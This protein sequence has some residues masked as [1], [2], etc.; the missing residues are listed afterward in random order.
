MSLQAEAVAT[1]T[2]EIATHTSVLDNLYNL[3]FASVVTVFLATLLVSAVLAIIIGI[4]SDSHSMEDL[5]TNFIILFVGMLF[6]LWL[7]VFFI[8]ILIE[9]PL[10]VAAF[11][12][13]AAGALIGSTA[14]LKKK[15]RI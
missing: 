7:I 9:A 14:I 2:A 8:K 10:M 11:S 15:G 3:N 5:L 4:F 12:G 1:L 6:I 13:I